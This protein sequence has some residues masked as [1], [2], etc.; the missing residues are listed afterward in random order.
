MKIELGNIIGFSKEERE[1]KGKI[2]ERSTRDKPN[3]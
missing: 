3:H 2:K 1:T